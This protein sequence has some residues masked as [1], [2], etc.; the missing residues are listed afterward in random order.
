LR[1]CN[2]TAGEKMTPEER[3][4]TIETKI[5]YL[6]NYVSEINQVI[7][8]QEETIKKLNLETEMLKKKIEQVEAQKLPENEKPPHY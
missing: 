8:D 3:L 7:I 5:A 6:E 1:N 4:I 2:I